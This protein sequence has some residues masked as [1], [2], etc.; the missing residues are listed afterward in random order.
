M[1]AIVTKTESSLE[2]RV[3]FAIISKYVKRDGVA[4][5]VGHKN[6]NTASGSS[7]FM[8]E[9]GFDAIMAFIDTDMLHK[10]WP[11]KKLSFQYEFCDPTYLSSG[12]LGRNI[13]IQHQCSKV[14]PQV[15]SQ[16]LSSD[17]LGS[18]LVPTAEIK[19]EPLIFKGFFEKS[20]CKWDQ[21]EYWSDITMH[22]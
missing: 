4:G 19:L 17:C 7:D 14:D 8:Y 9:D 11:K 21:D 3:V 16:T 5:Q 13:T 1:L 2:I 18:H 22:R 20:I 12:G 10:M 6:W 15:H